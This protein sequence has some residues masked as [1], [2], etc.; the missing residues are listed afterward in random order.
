MGRVV[1]TTDMAS[2][3]KLGI[4]DLESGSYYI[5]VIKD[6]MVEIKPFIKI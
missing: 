3:N 5:K 6:R 1:S 2:D 4:E